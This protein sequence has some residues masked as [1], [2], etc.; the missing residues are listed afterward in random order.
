MARL[1][2]QREPGDG[3][4]LSQFLLPDERGDWLSTEEI[5]DITSLFIRAGLDTVATALVHS[6]AYLARHRAERQR[7]VDD[8]SLILGAVEELIRTMTPAPALARVATEAVELGG[9]TVREGQ[10]VF[11]HSSTPPRSTRCCGV[12]VAPP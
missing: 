9:V 3:D 1:L 11:C 12:P 7:L 10:S 5:L 4:L 2:E 8:P 6:F